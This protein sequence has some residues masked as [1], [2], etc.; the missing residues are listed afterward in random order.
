LA[1]LRLQAVRE[2]RPPGETPFGGVSTTGLV[3]ALHV[4]GRQDHELVGLEH[5][6]AGR[7]GAEH[8]GGE[9]HHHGGSDEPEDRRLHGAGISWWGAARARKRGG[10]G[11]KGK[12]SLGSPLPGVNSSPREALRSRYGLCVPAVE[13]AGAFFTYR[14]NQSSA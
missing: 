11:G 13:G 9:P 4:G 7:G 8:D 10:L 2:T 14:S 6:G 3:L 5:L 1:V 12:S